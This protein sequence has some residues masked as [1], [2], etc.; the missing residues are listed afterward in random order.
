MQRTVTLPTRGIRSID[1]LHG[2]HTDD[3][4][5]VTS[6]LPLQQSDS[7]SLCSMCTPMLCLPRTSRPPPPFRAWRACR[8]SRHFASP[9]TLSLPDCHLPPSCAH[10]T[11]SIY[12]GSNKRVPASAARCYLQ[13]LDFWVDDALSSRLGPAAQTFSGAMLQRGNELPSRLRPISQPSPLRRD[14]DAMAAFH[15]CTPR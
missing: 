12:A 7:S 2:L 14:S 4:L 8:S 11:S 13:G 10:A 6:P 9:S 5:R 3:P 15:P 1:A